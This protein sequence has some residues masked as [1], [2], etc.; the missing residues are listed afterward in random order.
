MTRFEPVN[1][2][3]ACTVEAAVGIIPDMVSEHSPL[4]VAEQ[5]NHGYSHGGGWNPFKGFEFDPV[6]LTLK[7]P[8]DLAYYAIAQAT[9]HDETILVF[10]HAWVAIVQKNGDFEVARM[11]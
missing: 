2:H 10:S 7:Y 9:V 8:G 1:N 3:G 4:K 11:D 6:A 5:F